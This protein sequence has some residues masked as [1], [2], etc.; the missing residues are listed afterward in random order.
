MI[1]LTSM[2]GVTVDSEAR[3][4]TI[5]GS[6]TVADVLAVTT[7]LGLTAV[8]AAVASV[9]MVGFTLGGGYGPLSPKFGLAVD[10][11]IGAELVLANGE[12]VTVNAVEN[13]ELFWAI[14]GGG[15][16][17]GVVTSIRVR[18]HL[19]D[20]V[21]VA[22]IAFP[23]TNIRTT[24]QDYAESVATTPDELTTIPGLGS[25]PDGALSMMLA[26]VWCGEPEHA[27]RIFAQLGGLGKSSMV[28][29]AEM[30]CAE[31]LALFENNFVEGRSYA[32]ETRSLTFLN[33]E[34]IERFTQAIENRTSPYSSLAWHHCHGLPTRI[35]DGATSFG[36][37][38]GHFMVDLVATWDSE[39]RDQEH[40]HWRWVREFVSGGSANVSTQWISQYVRPECDRPDSICLLD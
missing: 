3:V 14:R 29:V 36:F 30:S 32:V 13:T 35:P 40:F 33:A 10:N 8:T 38:D 17:F 18:L 34:V 31:M 22:A 1:D 21:S 16:H 12:R 28:Q 24:L 11:L 20:R 23:W 25:G 9:G 7:P 39:S 4:A 19:V 37:R 2:R 5:E 27:E 26:A 6:A 15:G